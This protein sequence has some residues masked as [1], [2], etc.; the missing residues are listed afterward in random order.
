M[1]SLA[2]GCN[3]IMPHRVGKALEALINTKSI[4]PAV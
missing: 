3:Y 1:G 2:A 4:K